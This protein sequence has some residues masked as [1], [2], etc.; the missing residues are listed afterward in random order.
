[1]DRLSDLFFTR[2]ELAQIAADERATR[3]AQDVECVAVIDAHVIDALYDDDIFLADSNSNKKDK[4]PR[5]G[6][7]EELNRPS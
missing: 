2:Y 6:N 3:F 1:M 4:S 5:F 7:S